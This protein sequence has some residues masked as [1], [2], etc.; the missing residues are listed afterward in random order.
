MKMRH[1]DKNQ[2]VPGMNLSYM[3]LAKMC[4]ISAAFCKEHATSV[5]LELH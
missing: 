1:Q 3:V 5:E 4:S 2:Q